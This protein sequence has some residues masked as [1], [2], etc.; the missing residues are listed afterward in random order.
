MFNV[1]EKHQKAVKGILMAITAT[2]VVWG[3][4]G[5]LGMAGDDGYIAKVGNKKIYQADIDRAMD[6]SQGQKQDS[7]Q[8]LFGLINRQ[9]LINDLQDHHMSATDEQ[10]R[11]VIAAIPDFQTNGQ[12]DATKYEAFLKQQ[13]LTPAK[14]QD[15]MAQQVVI[16]Q[17]LDFFKNS[18]FTS[19]KFESQ[20]VK[21]LSRERDV[22]QYVI[23]PSQF[24]DKVN[25]SESDI[26]SY[27]QSHI[28]DYAVPE[29]VKL[30]YLQLSASDAVRNVQ[31]SD[32][33]IAS[34]IASHADAVSS[35]E[36][37]VSHILFSVPSDATATQKAQIK[38]KAEQVLAQVK[39]NPSQFAEL[40]KEYSQDPGS[41]TKG[42]DLG[43]FGK[44]VMV[45]AFESVAFTLQQGQIS[46]L[47]ETQFGYHILKLNATR[48]G[49]AADATVAAKQALQKQKAQQQIQTMVDQLNDITYNSPDSLDS[50]AKKLNLLNLFTS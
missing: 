36:V 23:S 47:V 19:T 22:S 17:M 10:L 49:S 32:S 11:Q 6:P 3:I 50:A 2:F 8:V 25:V 29:E 18:Y 15:S 37:D 31:V 34:Y 45:P 48:G 46:G 14:F 42:G 43:F 21:L 41:A 40:A 38:A 33:E 9:L 27:Y 12:F 24:M 28:Q 4:S 16:E 7:M 13:Y 35:K 30:Q 26:T 20:I 5:Y 44:G 1:V 39:S